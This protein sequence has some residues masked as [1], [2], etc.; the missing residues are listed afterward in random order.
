MYGWAERPIASSG[1]VHALRIHGR[2]RSILRKYILSAD[3]AQAEDKFPLSSVGCHA[4]SGSFYSS[5]K[6]EVRSTGHCPDCKNKRQ[7][8][9]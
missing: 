8:E 2:A 5:P 4:T 7:H 9:H 6:V 1:M 3:D